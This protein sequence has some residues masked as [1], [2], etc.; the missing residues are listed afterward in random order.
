[1]PDTPE[2]ILLYTLPPLREAAK[3]LKNEKIDVAVDNCIEYYLAH[4]DLFDLT[5]I[6]HFVVY[7][8]EAL[9]DL[10]REET[11]V[12][13]LSY[14]KEIIKEKGYVEATNEVSWICAPG[15]AQLAICWYKL[16]DLET[17]D[18]A[19]KWMEEHQT[20]FGGFY[21]SFGDGASY[22]E[23]EEISW[24]MK[25]YLDANK[26]RIRK[27]F[28]ENAGDAAVYPETI[29]S[30]DSRYQ[31]LKKFIKDGM[32]VAE[33]GCGKGRFLRNLNE[34]FNNLSL[35]G[36]DISEEMI[37]YLPDGIEGRVGELENTS[38]MDNCYDVVFCIEALEH[39]INRVAAL[40]EM[41]RILKKGGTLIIIDK[42]KEYWGR[43]NCP[44]W[45]NWFNKEE[46]VKEMEDFLSNVSYEELD[47]MNNSE[48]H[49]ICGWSGKKR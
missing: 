19:M 41:T 21:G 18:I 16:G 45:E 7:M 12:D 38:L 42:N 15:I 2:P 44:S 48:D 35:I 40:K 5:R 14:Y 24:A 26:L 32:K 34:D 36:V 49:L 11:V 28:N 6:T 23:K 33:I 27:F 13:I 46:L 22:L 9:I 31:Y 47:N 39:A 20:D 17:A 10:G 1:M 4:E 3:V 25:F 30:S 29:E 8:I 37:K 43:M